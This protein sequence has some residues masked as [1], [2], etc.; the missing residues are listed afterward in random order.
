M[1]DRTQ[2]INLKRMLYAELL[3]LNVGEMTDDDQRIGLALLS[4]SEI[5]EL[6]EKVKQ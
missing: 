5:Q 3:K 6:F 4:D 2:I 1:T